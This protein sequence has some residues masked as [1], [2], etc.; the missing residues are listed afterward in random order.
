MITVTNQWGTLYGGGFHYT[1][2]ID[3]D[4]FL[5]KFLSPAARNVLI[6]PGKEEGRV[7]TMEESRDFLDDYMSKDEDGLPRVHNMYWKQAMEWLKVA[8]DP[9]LTDNE[10]RI[11]ILLHL[12]HD[13][14]LGINACF[15]RCEKFGIF[16]KSYLNITND[17]TEFRRPGL[18]EEFNSQRAIKYKRGG[19]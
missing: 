2:I 14:Y 9:K 5:D 1:G 15:E 11:W 6:T 8:E 17:F 13:G 7:M 18:I 19:R 3:L 10:V 16:T 4:D 12:V